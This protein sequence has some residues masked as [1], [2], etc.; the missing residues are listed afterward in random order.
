MQIHGKEERVICYA[1]RTFNETEQQYTNT[2]WEVLANVCAVTK[3]FRLNS[4][5][6]K[7]KVYTDHKPLVGRCKLL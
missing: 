1:S 4:E 3:K 6:R 2:E 5:N 7:I